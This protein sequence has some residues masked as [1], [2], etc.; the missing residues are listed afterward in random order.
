MHIFG[1]K[2]LTLFL[3][4]LY[5]RTR[6]FLDVSAYSVSITSYQQGS[7]FWAEGRLCQQGVHVLICFKFLYKFFE[8]RRGSSKQS[9]LREIL[10][11]TQKYFP[12][13]RKN[14]FLQSSLSLQCCSHVNLLSFT[15]SCLRVER[16]ILFGL[17]LHFGLK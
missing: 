11:V 15:G 4:T 1:M 9:Y 6:R 8:T 10:F 3:Y 14:V 2:F 12:Q 13:T 17:C 5:F 16:E 7:N